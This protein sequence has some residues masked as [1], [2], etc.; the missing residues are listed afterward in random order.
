M[1][2]KPVARVSMPTSST[3]PATGLPH[4]TLAYVDATYQSNPTLTS[5]NNPEADANGNIAVAR[6]QNPR[7]FAMAIEDGGGL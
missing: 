2:A 6:G 4:T 1:R 7:H 5:A 3:E